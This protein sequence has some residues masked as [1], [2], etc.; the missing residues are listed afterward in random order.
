MTLFLVTLK[1]LIPL[2]H[3][4]KTISLLLHSKGKKNYI[5]R[6][7]STLS[8]EILWEEYKTMCIFLS[9][10]RKYSSIYSNNKAMR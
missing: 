6:V 1:S 7:K 4:K 8:P 10:I 9:K 2:F 5:G 3:L